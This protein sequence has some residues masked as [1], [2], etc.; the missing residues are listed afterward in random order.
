MQ[1]AARRVLVLSVM[2]FMA[3]H[4]AAA[5]SVFPAGLIV[6]ERG[7][8]WGGYTVLSRLQAPYVVVLDMNGKVVKQWDGFNTSA[9]GPVRIL[10]GGNVIAT[11][12]ANPGH[13]ESAALVA[14]DFSG[15]EL[16]RLDRN[17]T[18]TQADG[19]QVNSLRQHHDWQRSDFP[20]GY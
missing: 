5:P 18:I 9:G 12:G 11:A 1:A 4:L 13:Q 14:Q 15:K 17:V 2:L 10:P 6:D 16:W 8:T 3:G 19:K 7:A 20:A